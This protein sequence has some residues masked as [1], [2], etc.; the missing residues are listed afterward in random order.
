MGHW[1]R[2][3]IPRR[4]LI[5]TLFIA[6]ML[7]LLAIVQAPKSTRDGGVAVS[8]G[9][10]QSVALADFEKVAEL[11]LLDGW[12]PRFVGTQDP[13]QAQPWPFVGGF[14]QPWEP[15]SPYLEDQGVALNGPG[16]QSEVA[17][18]RGLEW[19]RIRFPVP[20]ASARLEPRQG[21]QLLVTLQSGRGRFETR[22]IEM[23]TLRVL[24]S[25]DSGPWSRFSWDGRSVLTG[26]ES[27]DGETQ[28][29]TAIPVN[30]E[31]APATL[32]SW[33]EAGMSP[34]PKGLPVKEDRLWAD[35]QDLQGARVAV[36]RG[37]DFRLWFPREDV[38]WTALGGRWIQWHL[39]DGTW[40][41]AAEGEGELRAMPPLAMGLVTPK[42][43]R[44]RGP[45]DRANWTEVETTVPAWPE[46]DPAWTWAGEGALTAWEQ[47]WGKGLETLGPERQREAL[48][49][50]HLPDWKVAVKL[51]A[52]VKG[53]L[54]DGPDIALRERSAVAWVWLGPR[55]IQERLQPTERVRRIRPLLQSR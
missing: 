49:K 20:I 37:K 8:A 14:E 18:W 2:N 9:N 42:G 34:A 13:D 10:G 28:L 17:L 27:P 50:A 38:L 22:L 29:L 41:R 15:A 40:R 36:P 55:I 11:A 5:A 3:V 53:W 26:L 30:H 1:I 47:R 32:A 52:S 35:G 6:G 4:Y 7:L 33:D 19:R 44:Q 23:A 48:R 43:V 12:S 21:R 24:W 31:P 45:V 54:P 16:S 39:E 25:V 51:R 46:Y